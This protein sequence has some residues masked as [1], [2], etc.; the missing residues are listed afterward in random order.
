MGLFDLPLHPS[1]L[2]KTKLSSNGI[3][4]HA[5]DPQKNPIQDNWRCSGKTEVCVVFLL[6]AFFSQLTLTLWES[7]LQSMPL[8]GTGGVQP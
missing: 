6:C 3:W 8:G 7:P 4:C 5:L 2:M 1:E